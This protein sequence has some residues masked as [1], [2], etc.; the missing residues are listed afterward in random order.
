[1]KAG[2]FDQAFDIGADISDSLELETAT[3]GAKVPPFQTQPSDS[4]TQHATLP[5][6]ADFETT[7]SDASA[8][9][10][11]LVEKANEAAVQAR[12]PM[13]SL[14]ESEAIIPPPPGSFTLGTGPSNSDEPNDLTDDTH[15]KSPAP[16]AAQEGIVAVETDKTPIAADSPSQI[17][18]SQQHE[19]MV[20]HADLE[21]VMPKGMLVD[22]PDWMI[23]SIDRE[24]IRLGVSS[25]AIIKIWIAERLEQ[26][27]VA[28]R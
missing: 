14:A 25:D 20:D 21:A 18:P 3:R 17:T 4:E 24:A 1:M 7:E 10:S 6:A 26:R 2:E 5:D 23:E 16:M 8:D 15:E 22:F 9:L 19:P 11:A 28:A 12:E 27:T 13:E